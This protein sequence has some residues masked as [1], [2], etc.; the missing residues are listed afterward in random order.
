L[1]EIFLSLR[2]TEQDVIVFVHRSSR[3]VPVILA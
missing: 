1:S 2:R 3:K